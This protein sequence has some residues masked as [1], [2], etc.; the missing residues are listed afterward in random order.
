MRPA[1]RSLPRTCWKSLL[2]ERN[3]L[4]NA[5][6]LNNCYRDIMRMTCKIPSIPTPFSVNIPTK[7]GDETAW[8]GEGMAQA[9]AAAVLVLR[10]G[11]RRADPSG[12]E[13]DL[14]SR[15]AMCG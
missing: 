12:N 13:L 4:K 8:P 14:G 7:Q 6:A 15:S 2:W 5:S 11:R 1:L 9:F 3:P 10:H